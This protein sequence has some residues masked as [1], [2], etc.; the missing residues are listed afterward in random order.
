M[1]I[2]RESK[3]RKLSLL[4]SVMSIE[5]DLLD[6]EVVKQAKEYMENVDFDTWLA[7]LKEGYNKVAVAAFML[8]AEPAIWKV[9][10][11]NYIG[12]NGKAAHSRITSG[13]YTE[14]LTT[15]YLNLIEPNENKS[16]SSDKSANPFLSFKPDRVSSDADKIAALIGWVQLYMRNWA[17]QLN[18]KA[19]RVSGENEIS[20]DERVE[21]LGDA[22][23]NDPD[24]DKSEVEEE[25]EKQEEDAE[26]EA[27]DKLMELAGDVRLNTPLAPRKNPNLNLRGLL[28][29]IIK[30]PE[31]LSQKRELAKAFGVS[32]NAMALRQPNPNK[33]C[34]LQ[35]L[36]LVLKDYEIGPFELNTI[37]NADD[38][39]AVLDILRAR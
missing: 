28:A 21:N 20:W 9:F 19:N 5:H 8:K 32:I 38:K 15:V 31:L 18:Y 24:S 29:L 25:F 4:E 35:K 1:F 26:D 6:P 39:D 14:F 2:F 37:I 16:G 13:E 12:S 23:F 3:N 22:A 33:G 17:I 34:F 10:W 11:R 30:Q 7:D 36:E 27:M